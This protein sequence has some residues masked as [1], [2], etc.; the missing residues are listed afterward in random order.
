MLTEFDEEYSGGHFSPVC[1]Y[2]DDWILFYD[3]W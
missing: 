3:V 1:G 2:N